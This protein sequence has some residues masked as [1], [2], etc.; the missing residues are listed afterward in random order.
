MTLILNAETR[1]GSLTQS[2]YSLGI[3]EHFST[4]FLVTFNEAP[5]V[6]WYTRFDNWGPT[7]CG[8]KTE[9]STDITSP[10]AT[11]SLSLPPF[12]T[13]LSAWPT[14]VQHVTSTHSCKCGSTTWSCVE[15]S[16]SATTLGHESI[17]L[18]Q[19]KLKNKYQASLCLSACCEVSS[20]VYTQLGNRPD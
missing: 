6:R 5:G 17:I 13:H 18:S 16:I 11:F 8:W 12:R 10:P 19:V 14:W 7:C 1:W 4:L 20:H 15:A 9:A 3:F 2:V